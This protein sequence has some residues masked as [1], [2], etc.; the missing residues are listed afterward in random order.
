MKS[1]KNRGKRNKQICKSTCR[2]W[3]KV[4]PFLGALLSTIGNIIAL[5]AKDISWLSQNLWVLALAIT[6]FV[7]EEMKQRRLQ[8]K[9]NFFLK[10]IIL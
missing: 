3:K 5:S 1:C 10:K 4:G 7:H 8:R 6:Y 2:N 9:N